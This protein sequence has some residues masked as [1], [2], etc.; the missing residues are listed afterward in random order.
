M[1]RVGRRGLCLPGHRSGQSLLLGTAGVG[2]CLV[3]SQSCVSGFWAE[4]CAGQVVP[5]TENCD[6]LSDE[7]CDGAVDEDWPTLDEVCNVGLGDCL[8]TGNLVCNMA[9]DAV[10]CD[11][12]PGPASDEVCDGQHDEDCDGA[13]DE[14]W[15]NLDGA[16]SIGLGQCLRTGSFVCDTAGDSVVCDVQPGQPGDE[17]CEGQ[18]DENC[19]GSIDEGC[20]CTTGTSRACPL[21]HGVCAGSNQT[22]QDASWSACQ[23]GSGYESEEMSCDDMDNDCDG[24][25]DEACSDDIEDPDPPSTQTIEGGCACRS[26]SKPPTSGFFWTVFLVACLL[27][28]R[29]SS[30]RQ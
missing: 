16:C 26:S 11:A 8:R 5:Q 1:R 9:G 10:E 29:S 4:D 25:T 23:Y 17:V 30:G 28:Q 12:Q 7:D 20:E 6:G 2:A 13:V 21:T 22:C 3:G 14:N 19:D 24:Y 18:L 27:I 15:S